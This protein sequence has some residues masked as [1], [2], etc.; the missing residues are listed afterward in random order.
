MFNDNKKIKESSYIVEPSGFGK[1][2]VEGIPVG[3]TSGISLNGLQ[4]SLIGTGSTSDSWK[5]C[6]SGRWYFLKRPKKQ[7]A[8]NP[9]YLECFERV[10]DWV[11]A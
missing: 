5:I 2:V 9:K 4:D 3:K 8:D 1:S 6:I 11:S 10:S 7:Y